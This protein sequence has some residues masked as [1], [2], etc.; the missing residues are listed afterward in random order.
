MDSLNADFHLSDRSW[1]PR[2]IV[3]AAPGPQRQRAGG[4]AG[5]CL[6]KIG[7]HCLALPI[8]TEASLSSGAPRR[9]V[10]SKPDFGLFRLQARRVASRDPACRAGQQ[11]WFD[12][13]SRFHA[14]PI[15]TSTEASTSARGGCRR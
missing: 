10:R 4:Q 2:S 5:C 11:R 1:G 12:L 8:C 14:R 7:V 6:E 15:R 3:G 9:L 13:A